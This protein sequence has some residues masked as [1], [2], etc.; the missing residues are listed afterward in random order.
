MTAGRVCNETVRIDLP[1]ESA[2]DALARRL[3]GLARVGDVIAL[4]GDLGTGKT[5]FARAFINALP[6]AAGA[7]SGPRPEE[8]PSP[9]FTLIQIYERVPAP[10]WHVDLYRL[11]HPGEADE[12]GLE[13]AFAEAI[14]VIEWPD[15]LGDRLPVERL[16]LTLSYT[17]SPSA[18]QATLRA[19]DGW[20][21]RLAAAGL[22]AKGRLVESTSHV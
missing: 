2:T 3:A 1:D 12:L 10:V 7:S 19:S 15:R 18:R 17:A 9:T 4:S 22:W 5:R 6:P 8:V 16:D 11:A 14:T 13:E 21:V 20:R